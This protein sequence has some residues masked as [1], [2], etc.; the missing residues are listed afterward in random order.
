MTPKR[1]GLSHFG[2]VHFAHDSKALYFEE[3]ADSTVHR[4]V[5]PGRTQE[6]VARLE[7]LPRPN[8]PYWIYWTGLTHDDSVLAM[9][10]TGIQEIYSL[11]DCVVSPIFVF[12]GSLVPGSDHSPGPNISAA[13][14]RQVLNLSQQGCAGCWDY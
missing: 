3:T 13:T 1:I 8:M 9:Q 4:L 2:D 7:D 12:D 14:A 5:L 6:V 11:A 10:D